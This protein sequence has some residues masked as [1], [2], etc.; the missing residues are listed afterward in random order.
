M[1]SR[2]GAIASLTLASLTLAALVA[3]AG[4][5]DDFKLRYFSLTRFLH[6]EDL[7]QIDPPHQAQASER[8]AR[9]DLAELLPG[10]PP[11][12]GIPSLDSPQFETAATTPFRAED[13]VIGLVIHGEAKAYPL[14]VMNWHEIVNDT[15]GGVPVAVTYCPLCDTAIVFERGATTLGVS[16]QLYQS[17]LV[18][19]DR[20]DDTFYA[21]PWGIGIVGPQVNRS[22]QRQPAV[23][24]T[25]GQWLQA[26]PESQ[27]LSTQTGHRRDYLRYPYGSYDTNEQLIFPA[28]HQDQRELHP[29]ASLSY[30]WE[31]D[32]MTPHNQFS[33]ASQ[34]FS[35]A[36]VQQQGEQVVLFNGRSVR[37]VWDAALATVRVEELDG[38]EIPSATAFAFVYPAYF[39]SGLGTEE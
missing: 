39:G 37:A 23:K 20:D 15:V 19:Y 30:I 29:K 34:A 12:D 26:H 16:G 3:Q 18:M 35:H 14:G 6:G 31:A 1:L 5:W 24:T 36:A 27:I 10:G 2:P 28:R 11:K 38:R 21:Q 9:I 22:L 8:A 32:S 7:A 4:G 25:L 33:G 13:A 17:C